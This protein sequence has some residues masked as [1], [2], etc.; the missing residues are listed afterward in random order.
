MVFLEKILQSYTEGNGL[1]SVTMVVGFE[2]LRYKNK[3]E[4]YD[5]L[6]CEENVSD[7]RWHLCNLDYQHCIT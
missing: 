7:H 6:V 5:T 2:A 3:T 1:S 4:I